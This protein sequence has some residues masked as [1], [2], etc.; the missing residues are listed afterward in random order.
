MRVQPNFGLNQAQLQKIIVI[1]TR[2][3]ETIAESSC[4]YVDAEKLQIE[5]GGHGKYVGKKLERW[6][7]R[8]VKCISSVLL[9][10][11]G[12]CLWRK[13]VTRA[14]SYGACMKCGEEAPDGNRQIELADDLRAQVADELLKRREETEWIIEGDFDIYV[15]RIQQPYVWGGEPELLVASHVLRCVL[16]LQTSSIYVDLI[17]TSVI[18]NKPDTEENYSTFKQNI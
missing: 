13:W 2:N 10:R 1:S 18:V 12:G 16:I 15:K 7:P 11:K 5:E 8:V 14:V 3:F 17:V 4:D 6:G 9:G